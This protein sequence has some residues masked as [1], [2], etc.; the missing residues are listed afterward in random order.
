MNKGT[1]DHSSSLRIAKDALSYIERLKLSAE[2]CSY[3]LWYAYAAGD[4]LALRSAIDDILVHADAISSLELDAIR[5][6]HLAVHQPTERLGQIGEKLGDE[7]EQV[8]SM[9]EAAIGISMDFDGELQSS[10]QRLALPIDRATLRGIIEAVV[11][12]TRDM[13]QENTKL[14]QNLERSRQDISKLEENLLETRNES[15]TDPLTG[16]SNRRHFDQE[17]ANAL[18]EAER[19]GKSFSLLLADVDHFKM[20]NDGH[21]H[22][23][24]DRVLRLIATSLKQSVRGHDLVARYGGEEFAIILVDTTLRQAVTVAENLRRAVA[25]KDVIMQPTGER[26]G[27]ITLS[28]GVASFR[29]GVAVQA[30]IDAADACLYAAKN[31]GRNRVIC[32]TEMD[33]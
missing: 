33:R 20:I 13:Q 1:Q 18:A 21:G 24:G 8:V 29:H 5:K 3:E 11:T 31:N 16:L 23:I 12:A 32:E 25:T 30:L 17:L 26:L 19:T 27:R 15:L 14:G 2:P 10:N 6:R 28:I 22:R 9:I 4:N 7:V